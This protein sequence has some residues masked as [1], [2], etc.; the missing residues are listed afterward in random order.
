MN[1]V[2]LRLYGI[3]GPDNA[4]GRDLG[5]LVAAAVA[6]GC[7]LIQ[8]RDKT[9]PTRALVETARSIKAA[10]RGS[11]VPL[12][13]NDR[14]DVAL[15]A[16]ADGVHLGQDDM[17]VRDARA[18]LGPRAIIGLTLKTSADAA[19]LASE[20]ADYGCI[21]GVFATASKTNPEPPIGLDGLAAAVAAGRGAGM[22]L[23]AIAGIDA[24]N[25]AA[26]IGAGADGIAVI[27]AVF[28]ADDPTAAA[29][30]L[31]AVVD[32]ALAARGA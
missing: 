7:T 2:D 5:A 18:L 24:G 17:R 12:L 13:V 9:S 23:G 26:V 22:P 29:R 19:A 27:S 14:V 31:R 28:N 4:R 3:V 20:P 21:G 11:G 25:A 6:G 32:G 15:A 16:G 1:P 10:L 30:R 8:L